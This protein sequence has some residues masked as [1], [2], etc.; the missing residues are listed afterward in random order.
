MPSANDEYTAGADVT[1]GW[2]WAPLVTLTATA[3]PI[4]MGLSLV[5]SALTMIFAWL[6]GRRRL[7]FASKAEH[8][9]CKWAAHGPTCSC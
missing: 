9:A 4:V 6:A 5:A 8:S 1:G 7:R 3:G 2:L